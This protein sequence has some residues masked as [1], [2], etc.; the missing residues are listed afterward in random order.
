MLASHLRTSARAVLA[1]V[2]PAVTLRTPSGLQIAAPMSLPCDAFPGDAF[3]ARPGSL[4]SCLRIH[5][6]FLRNTRCSLKLHGA[7][8]CD[9]SAG[10]PF[11]F[12]FSPWGRGSSL[13]HERYSLWSACSST[14]QVVTCAININEIHVYIKWMNDW[15]LGWLIDSGAMKGQVLAKVRSR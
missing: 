14:C 5:A 15:C 10:T 7:L 11:R 4:S 13:Y 8:N 1:T 3:R 9:R 2:I 12:L 6:T